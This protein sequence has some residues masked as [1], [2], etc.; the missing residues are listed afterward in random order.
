MAPTRRGFLGAAG[1]AGLGAGFG[2]GT[3]GLLET[4]RPA[5]TKPPG[6]VVP[7]YGSHQAG[8]VTP[9][10]EHLQFAAFD[11]MGDSR[12]DLRGLLRDWTHG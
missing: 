12:D 6:E 9:S 3:S 5:R 1:L 11:L 2:L 8:I 7:F 10:Q 4:N